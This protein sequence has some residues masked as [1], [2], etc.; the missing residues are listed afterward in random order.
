MSADDFAFLKEDRK[1][2]HAAAY[3]ANLAALRA[4]GAVFKLTANCTACLFR[5]P[6]RAWPDF[7]PHTGRWN[8][9]GKTYSGGAAAFL[10]WYEKAGR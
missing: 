9:G 5:E 7:Y 10:D 4:A 1:S 6:G 2:R 3:E 8:C